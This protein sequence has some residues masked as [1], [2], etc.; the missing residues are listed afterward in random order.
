MGSV[1]HEAF[2]LERPGTGVVR[3][4]NVESPRAEVETMEAKPTGLLQDDRL[5][6]SIDVPLPP[7]GLAHPMGLADWRG[8][9]ALELWVEVD[10][11]PVRIRLAGRL[12]ATTA[13]N[14]DEVVGELLADGTRAIELCTDG[15]RVV[16]ASAIGTLAD[17]ERRVRL[18]GGTL[19]RV[20]PASG[21]FTR[22]RFGSGQPPGHR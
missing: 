8:D 10:V 19:I 6:G 20:A 16:D 13:A 17:I 21:P 4:A 2:G 7:V 9:V 14:L 11:V 3:R 1:G 22:S 18:D 5:A 12:D 15:L